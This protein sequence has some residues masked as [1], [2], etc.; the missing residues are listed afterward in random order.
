MCHNCHALRLPDK[1]AE[2]GCLHA[3]VEAGRASWTF[4]AFLQHKN[5]DNSLQMELQHPDPD[6]I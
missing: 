1:G 2:L 5:S 4:L 3:G 6:R